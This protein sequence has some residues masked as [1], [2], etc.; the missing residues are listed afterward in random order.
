MTLTKSGYFGYAG[1]GKNGAVVD[2]WL[3][4]RFVGAPAEDSSP[5]T[6][7]AD[8]GPVTTTI[9][10]GGPGS[11]LLT[12]PSAAD[13]YIRIQY[14]NH[15]YWSFC[16][17]GSIGGQSGGGG[18]GALLAINNLSDLTNAAT[19]RANL[20]VSTI[21]P[22]TV[23]T[24]HYDGTTDDAS[25]INTQLATLAAAGGGT[26]WL[27]AGQN[28]C[29]IT[30]DILVPGGVMLRGFGPFKRKNPGSSI[31]SY[32]ANGWLGT[33]IAPLAGATFTL[34]MVVLNGNSAQLEQVEVVPGIT[35][36]VGVYVNDLGCVVRHCV[37]WGGTTASLDTAGSNLSQD[38]VF[39]TTIVFLPAA[40]SGVQATSFTGTTGTALSALS[41]LPM[42]STAKWPASGAGTIATSGGTHT[43]TYTSVASPISLAGCVFSAPTTDTVT[44]GATIA[45][46][47]DTSN[48]GFRINSADN[49][50]LG[51]QSLGGTVV[52]NSADCIHN[53][54]HYSGNVT[55]GAYNVIVNTAQ[56]TVFNGG[57]IDNGLAAL[58]GGWVRRDKG[59]V[60][61]NGVNLLNGQGQY[62]GGSPPISGLLVDNEPSPQ[63][64]GFLVS[65]CHVPNVQIPG[66]AFLI[67][68]NFGSNPNSVVN[69][70]VVDPHGIVSQNEVHSNCTAVPGNSF[71]TPASMTGITVGARVYAITGSGLIA[72]STV[73]A[74]NSP[75][76]GQVAISTTLGGGA[77]SGY[78]AFQPTP[79]LANLY[80]GGTPGVSRSV[81]YGGTLQAELPGSAVANLY[82][83]PAAFTFAYGAAAG[84]GPTG[85]TWSGYAFSFTL[86]TATAAGTLVTITHSLGYV[87]NVRIVMPESLSIASSKPYVISASTTT[88]VV[89]VQA[90]PTASAAASFDLYLAS[91]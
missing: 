59:T 45:G 51:V 91:N 13:Y 6:G 61:L 49:I 14:G 83:A 31:P 55:G 4:S 46:S 43:F 87:P 85:G 12:M 40:M 18:A 79:T 76:T 16:S 67:Q 34:G 53:G 41:T 63:L 65:D 32:T 78:F 9:A 39:D 84:T 10:F 64:G 57:T 19:A 29:M 27:P 15:A 11:Y 86:G 28:P 71:L 3:A 56:G 25:S 80:N 82:A 1:G 70:L 24:R 88:I 37:I 22:G 20:G 44:N 35:A 90:A 17:A 68:H 47:P 66:S 21:V 52:V 33:C 60:V 42:G 50:M 74:L 72:G 81:V 2:A 5:P 73:T 8:A 62:I 23:L 7:T 26:A 77:A 36:P 38:F 89:G 54:C 58:N 30:T 69:G 48:L 75:T